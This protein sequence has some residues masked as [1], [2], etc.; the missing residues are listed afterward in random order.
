[1]TVPKY[2]VCTPKPSG[3]HFSA[4]ARRG[5]ES[6]EDGGALWLSSHEE[7]PSYLPSCNTEVK[8]RVSGLSTIS[9]YHKTQGFKQHFKAEGIEK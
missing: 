4:Q 2:N 3:V 8:C 9:C 6:E 5:D 7:T 1:M